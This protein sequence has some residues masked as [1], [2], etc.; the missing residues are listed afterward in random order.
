MDH[1]RP[2]AMRSR[3][4]PH[5]RRSAPRVDGVRAFRIVLLLVLAL[6]QVGNA[7]RQ[8]PSTLTRPT[9]RTPTPAAPRGASR[10]LLA[11]A[12]L[13]C[14]PGCVDANS[15]CQTGTTNGAC[16][17][18]GG[19]CMQYATD[20]VCQNRVCVAAFDCTSSCPSGCCSGGQCVAFQSQTNA[21]CGS[22]GSICLAC[23][24]GTVCYGGS[25]CT[26]I[27]RGTACSGHTCDQFASD[28][29]GGTY[30]CD[31]CPQGTT[32]GKCQVG[33]CSNSSGSCF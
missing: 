22:G 31:N 6:T 1:G 29:C 33:V 5:V 7:G 25:C 18:G 12:C 21:A 2:S 19:A 13:P 27:P 20:Q 9:Q 32:C 14:T 8:T 26:P 30:S 15:A 11:Q 23:A 28:G 16:G 4:L 3:L 17:S 10:L 24:T